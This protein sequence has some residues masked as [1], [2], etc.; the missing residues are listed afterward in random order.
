MTGN[1]ILAV[2][3]AIAK[4]F[5]LVLIVLALIVT[6]LKVRRNLNAGRS[7]DAAWRGE[8]LFYVVG[9]GYAC[10]GLLRAY[11]QGGAASEIGWQPSP[12]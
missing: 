3:A 12:L 1:Q 11:A 5:G 10:T 7:G 9:I 4:N 2:I 8:L 6:R